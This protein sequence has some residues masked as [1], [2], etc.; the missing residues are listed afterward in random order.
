MARILP[1][2]SVWLSFF[3]LLSPSVIAQNWMGANSGYAGFFFTGGSKGTPANQP[4]IFTTSLSADGITWQNRGG[5]WTD[6]YPWIN[7][8]D[9]MYWNGKFYVSTSLANDQNYSLYQVPI[10]RADASTGQF[11][12]IAVLDWASAISGLTVCF[13]PGWVHN[14]DDSVYT[15]DGNVHLHVPCSIGD[16]SHFKVYET[17]ISTSNLA[18]C[19]SSGLCSAFW[20]V[21]VDTNVS[22]ANMIDAHTYLINGTFWMWIKDETNKVIVLASGPSVT[23][24]FTMVK[25]GDW[26][27]WGSNLEGSFAYRNGAGWTLTFETYLATPHQM[28]YT[29]CTTLDF[30]ACTWTAKQPFV[31]D[32]WYRHGSTIKLSP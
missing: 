12:T 7:G 30:T 16:S 21:P 24:P 3:L 17:H 10:A 20:S 32:M 11:T 28:Y 2:K 22:Q 29:T 19:G 1:V 6:Y 26:A 13:A 25:T 15:D 4:N 8:S 5:G 14:S 23:G 27:G 9:T 31:E 18:S